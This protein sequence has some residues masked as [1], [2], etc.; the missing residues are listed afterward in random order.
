MSLKWTRNTSQTC[1]RCGHVNKKN[2]SQTVFKCRKCGYEN[3]AD[4]VA[5]LNVALR[6]L[7]GPGISSGPEKAAVNQLSPMIAVTQKQEKSHPIL[8]SGSL[9]LVFMPNKNKSSKYRLNK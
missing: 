1:P 9:R 7:S 8:V 4:R 5:S 3:N 2:R 6:G